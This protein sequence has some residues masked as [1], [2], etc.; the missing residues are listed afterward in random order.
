MKT[1]RRSLRNCMVPYVGKGTTRVL[2]VSKKKNMWYGVMKEFD[3]KVSST[4][5]VCGKVRAEAVTHKHL[6]KDRKE[7][8]SQ[9]DYIIGPVGRND[10]VYIHN[11]GRL[12]H[13]PP[14]DHYPLFARIEEEPH[15][16]VFQKRNKKWTGWK[17][18]TEEQLSLFKREAMKNERD[19]Q[20]DLST[21]QKNI[22][23]AAKKIQH[24]TNAQ[25]EKEMMKTP[26]NV[27]LREGAVARCTAEIKRSVLRRQ[28]RK[29][30]AEHLVKCS[31]VPGKKKAKRRPMTELYVN[32]PFT[33]DR[34]EWQKE[35][36]RH[37]EEVY[38]DIE[39]TR[40]EQENRIEYFWK[41]GN[42]QFTEDGRTAEITVDPVL[43]ARAKHSENN[44]NGPEDAIVSE[45]I[46]RL[47][48]EKIYTITRCFQERFLGRMEYPSWWKEKLVFLRKPDS[49]PTIEIRRY[50][51]IA[52]TS[53]ISKW[54]ASCI[55][56]RLEK[57]KE[58]E[59]WKKLHIGGL[60]GIS[61]QNVQVMMTSVIQKHW[62]WQ[63]EGN[64]VKKHGTV[65][66]PTLCLASLD[67]KTAFDEARTKH[68]AKIM[69]SHN[70]HGWTIAA[71]LR[72]MSGL[73]GK[74]MFEYR[75]AAN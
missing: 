12:W 33:E 11:A 50:R 4:W 26:E 28:A 25:K 15:V 36:Q 52:L 1:E 37:C 9:L 69:D 2:E 51:A 72:E 6:G 39:E 14:W 41:K 68:V 42:Q 63:E 55:Q 18:T 10:E 7:D 8:L 20:D 57:E 35:L 71:L 67:I 32:G 16:K 58:P 5:S 23:T 60:D 53:V 48:T 34:S 66:R 64:P 22:E 21:A 45:M 54:S 44:V 65:V 29:A 30:R 40:E 13:G 19:I 46:K 49:A 43:Q 75:K 47:P 62:E 24:R 70:T 61:C 74:A 17:P 73:S 59:K 38:T 31:L 27:R 56:L 3:C